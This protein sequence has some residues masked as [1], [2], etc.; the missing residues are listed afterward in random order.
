MF[1][2][3]FLNYAVDYYYYCYYTGKQIFEIFCKIAE[4]QISSIMPVFK[5]LVGHFGV[6][7]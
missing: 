2:D 5:L 4:M 6:L 7:I 3:D 1:Y